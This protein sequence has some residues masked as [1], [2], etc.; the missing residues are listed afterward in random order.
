M[1]PRDSILT[2]SSVERIWIFDR[3]Y[4]SIPTSIRV[5]SRCTFIVQ[6]A[7]TPAL[8]RAVLVDSEDIPL[9]GSTRPDLTISGANITDRRIPNGPLKICLHSNISSLTVLGMK[10]ENG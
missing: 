1:R 9:G 5:E 8:L 10:F 6:G 4:T 7:D 3:T 2:L